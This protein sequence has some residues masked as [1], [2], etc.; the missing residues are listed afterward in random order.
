MDN[1]LK[2]SIAFT[3]NTRNDITKFEI[4]RLH[5]DMLSY[6]EYDQLHYDEIITEADLVG[7]CGVVYAKLVM[8]SSFQ[9][10]NVNGNI[11]SLDINKN[12]MYTPQFVNTFN[13]F[14]HSIFEYFRFNEINSTERH[15]DFIHYF[16]TLT[17][18]IMDCD[19]YETEIELDDEYSTHIT[20][21]FCNYVN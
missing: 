19:I 14:M 5:N 7:S 20:I 6:T 9:C 12:Y 13:D 1:M 8:L 16:Y 11:Y 21:E 17:L 10:D 18:E 2:S 4:I 3:M 15:I